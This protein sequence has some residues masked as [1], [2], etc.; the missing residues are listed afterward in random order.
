MADD[1]NLDEQQAHHHFAASCF[2]RTWDLLDKVDRTAQETIEMIHT[3]HASRWHWAKSD[4][5]TPKNLAISAWQ[6]SRV[7]AVTGHADMA[8][9]YGEDSLHTS[10]LNELP[11]FFTAYAHEAIARAHG[12]A[13]RSA[14]RDAALAEARQFGE[15]IPEEENRK[16]L[17]AD[18]DTIT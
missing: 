2:N 10:L 18:L 11:A 3:A 6:L 15:Q 5:C 9:S 8:L 17:A 14:E 7:Y 16:A 12:T 13:G 4:N 1:A